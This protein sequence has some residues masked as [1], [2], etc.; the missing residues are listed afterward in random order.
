MPSRSRKPKRR[1]TTAQQAGHRAYTPLDFNSIVKRAHALARH[2]ETNRTAIERILLRYESYEVV[3]DEIRRT[4]DILE[5]LHENKQ[6]FKLRVGDVATF[7]PRNQPLYALTCFVIV[8]SLMATRVHFRIPNSMRAMLP[9][10]LCALELQRTFPN[11]LVSSLQRQEFLRER[12]ALRVDPS[13]GATK[14]VT[15]VVIFTGLPRHAEQLRLI[16]D[17]RTLFIANGAGHNPV[18]VGPDADITEAVQAVVT[19]QLYNQGQDCAAPNAVLVHAD[20]YENFVNSLVDELKTVR[21]GEY[22]D[23]SCRVGPISDPADIVRIQDFMIRHREYLHPE[24]P[25]HVRSAAAIVE[26][27]VIV[28]PLH[29][30]GNYSELFAPII[31]VQR[32]DDDSEL[33]AYFETPEYALHAMYI[34]LYGS[35]EYVRSLIGREVNGHILHDASSFLHDTHLHAPGIERGTKPYGGNGRGASSISYQNMLVSKA[36]LPQRDIHEYISRRLLRG[37]QWKT[38]ARLEKKYSGLEYKKIEK[39]LQEPATHR[40][41][42]GSDVIDGIIVDAAHI[43]NGTVRYATLDSKYAYRL[44]RTQNL[45]YIARLQL[46]DLDMLR[47]LNN[48]L[49]KRH[50]L[51]QEAFN[52][53]LYAIPAPPRATPS[54]KREAQKKF[55]VHVY[56]LLFGTATG[57]KLTVF[58]REFNLQQLRHLLD[59]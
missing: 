49:I 55:F 28:K 33:A 59:I 7:L 8:P 26:P 18:I 3:E 57:P 48:L 37:T 51:D 56:Q 32:F 23:M 34:T 17:A 53:E 27:A 2:I 9:D 30:G 14:P 47:S 24:T 20:A 35:S 1:S 19:L 21:T 11:V 22:A 43:H 13:T 54:R 50:T 44:L 15:D 42:T 16:F 39:L 12:T 10:L 5:H 36:T 29:T 25:G 31:V 4:L 52:T 41:D 46:R 38:H 6:Y 45:A 58:L 40:P